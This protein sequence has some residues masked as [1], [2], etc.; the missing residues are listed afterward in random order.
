MEEKYTQKDTYFFNKDIALQE[1]NKQHRVY[2]N[3]T[4]IDGLQ[5]CYY[6]CDTPLQDAPLNCIYVPLEDVY[7]YFATT[8]NRF[9]K[10]INFDNTEFSLAEQTEI[11]SQF[12]AVMNAAIIERKNLEQ[13]Y[14]EEINKQVPNFQDE[15]LRIFIPAC[16]ETTVMQ[17]VSKNIAQ[18]LEELGYNVR[19]FIQ[20]DEMQ[21]CSDRLPLFV[22]L[23]GFKP[24]VF[25][26]INHLNND[27]INENVFNF[28]WFQDP[29]PA[30]YN[31]SPINVR[32]RDY[33]YT[34]FDEYTEALVKK[35]VDKNK[36]TH[37]P[38]ATNPKLFNKDESI[39][40][41]DKVVFLGSDYNFD[42]QTQ[43]D[44]ECMERIYEK[45]EKNE[46][47]MQFIKDIADEYAFE[48][49]HF[50][51]YIIPSLVRRRVVIWL[52]SLED[53]EVEVYGTDT[54]LQNPEVVPY[55]KGLLPY[56]KEMSKVY[57]GAKYALAAHPQ[58]R[59]QQRVIEMSACGT[60][61]IVYDCPLVTE[62]FYHDD[63]VLSFSTFEQ[64]KQCIG[65]EPKE[66]PAKIA[67][68]ISYKNM[69]KDIINKVQ[70]HLKGE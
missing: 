36:I 44:N 43:I 26:G 2:T 65:K 18:A 70:T 31:D 50:K 29:M 45:I 11:Q 41:K 32:D 13:I 56:G 17:Y 53:V 42:E 34:L 27:I 35:G 59:Y 61:P 55:Y 7:N 68:D 28:I 39:K 49:E 24:H 69:A 38:F 20:D 23:H 21:T 22:D 15:E 52:C 3:S 62:N 16:R 54:W 14:R 51:M 58:Y 67:E 40:R 30:L 37:Q 57:N 1:A 25:I 10:I 47:T 9:P 64:L 12:N 66:D 46:L 19:F 4:E 48:F 60:I 63:N 33:I 8:K 5:I 6:T